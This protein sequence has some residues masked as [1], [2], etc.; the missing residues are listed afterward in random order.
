[1]IGGGG[2]FR[3]ATA[4]ETR[5]SPPFRH[6]PALVPIHI[7]LVVAC[8]MLLIGNWQ[9][10][11]T[12]TGLPTTHAGDAGEIPDPTNPLPSSNL[13]A[14]RPVINWLVEGLDDNSICI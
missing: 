2:E 4:A 11:G 8:H 3:W 6:H 7:W 14:G 12:E 9:P 1:M 10:M 5:N 13:C